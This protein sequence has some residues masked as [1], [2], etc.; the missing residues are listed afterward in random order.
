MSRRSEIV[1]RAQV[2][3]QAAI[4]RGRA[5]RAEVAAEARRAL[6]ASGPAARAAIDAHTAA[7]DR[8]FERYQQA[9]GEIDERVVAAEIDAAAAEEEA[10]QAA[11]ARWQGATE[12][13]AD[14]RDAARRHAEA[15]FEMAGADAQLLAGPARDAARA[16]HRRRRDAALQAADR[17]FARDDDEAWRAY[18]RALTQARERAVALIDAARAKQAG[19]AGKAAAAHEEERARAERALQGALAADPSAAALHATFERRLAEV[20]AATERD[21]QGVLDRMRADLAAAQPRP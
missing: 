8:A 7:I 5:L 20:D 2:E 10:R 11:Q 1:E 17:A 14:K 6:A 18:Q 16:D 21:K 19:A 12:A 9:M 15:D 13:A 4:D 3:F